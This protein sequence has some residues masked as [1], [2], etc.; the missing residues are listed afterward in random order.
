MELD[1]SCGD[2]V[3]DN[4]RAFS[5]TLESPENSLHWESL[6]HQDGDC[7]L[8][9]PKE[10][11]EYFRSDLHKLPSDRMPETSEDIQILAFWSC[12]LGYIEAL[13]TH[14]QRR[15]HVY[16]VPLDALK[17]LVRT[18]FLPFLESIGTVNN[19][20]N[21]KPLPKIDKTNKQ[22]SSGNINNKTKN[23]SMHRQMVR[24]VS[25]GVWG[26]VVPKTHI[27]DEQH[28]NSL[29]ICLRGHIDKK[30]LDCFGAAVVTITGCLLKGL[31]SRLTLSEDHAYE[32][33]TNEKEIAGTCEVAVP[34]STKLAQ[35]RRGIEIAETF[36][37][38]DSK[39]TLT[40]ERS[41]LYMASNSVVCDSIPMT[42]V[43]VVG[44]MNCTIE[45]TTK[46]FFASRQLYTIKRDLLWTLRDLGHMS[47]FPFG[48][49][50]LGDCEEH[51][52]SNRGL[53]WVTTREIEEQVLMN[54]K[55]FLDAI[56]INKEIYD[57]SQTYPYFCR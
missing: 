25:N 28:A 7:L 49:I 41:W 29:Y 52:G 30:S 32:Q 9:S 40:P 31:K 35:S 50:E 46:G 18:E 19:S 21:N 37:R 47:R 16:P 56:Q 33:H 23:D 39:C 8:R 26:K 38:K 27:K 1:D 14:K 6:I 45:K 55:L 36:D 34:G 57:D 44:N 17:R 20:N 54:E 12:C 13:A 42:L 3:D 48:L 10:I 53:E 11:L 22:K 51:C 15:Y 2:V 43:A 4:N 5:S 24:N